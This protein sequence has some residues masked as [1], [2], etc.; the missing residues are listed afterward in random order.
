M[1]DSTPINLLW[2]GGWDS[3]FRLLELLLIERKC[4]QPYYIVDHERKSTEYEFK[5]ME[6][7]KAELFM[8]YPEAGELLLPTKIGYRNKVKTD[9]EITSKWKVLRSKFELGAQY[10]WLPL[11]AK[12]HGLNDL[13]IGSE[14]K[15]KIGPWGKALRPELIGE[16]HNCRTKDELH[17]KELSILKYFR[18]PIF[19]KTKIDMERIS[20]ENDFFDI[21]RMIW[22]CH[23][24][25]KNGKPCELCQPCLLARKSQH[26]HGLPETNWFRNKW[27]FFSFQLSRVWE[28]LLEKGKRIVPKLIRMS[29]SLRARANAKES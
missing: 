2:T 16:G 4:V 24:P 23:T 12:Q 1:D 22:F 13:E 7:I 27:V 5:A 15:I 8:K 11:F 9:E 25:R 29:R 14:K 17:L 19:N 21:M 6:S 26:S 28:R 10:E 20:K 18:F 3:T